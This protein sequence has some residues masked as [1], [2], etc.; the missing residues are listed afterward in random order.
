VRFAPLVEE[1][2]AGFDFHLHTIFA[3]CFIA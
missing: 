1:T 2:A 3:A